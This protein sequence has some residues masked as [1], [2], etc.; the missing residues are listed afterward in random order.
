MNIISFDTAYALYPRAT[1]EER[2]SLIC[3]EADGLDKYRARGWKML[4]HLTMEERYSHKSSFRIGYRWIDDNISWIIP[5][6]TDDLLISEDHPFDPSSLTNWKLQYDVWKHHTT[7]TCDRIEIPRL[8]H[9]YVITDDRVR[10]VA[11]ELWRARVGTIYSKF[12]V[13]LLHLCTNN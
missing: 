7:I 10:E 1:F 6:N 3:R 13:P 5:L 4:Y 11:C 9:S 8:R 12:V 2:R